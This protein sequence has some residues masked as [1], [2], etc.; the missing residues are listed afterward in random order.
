MRSIA[1]ALFEDVVSKASASVGDMRC[2]DLCRYCHIF[3]SEYGTRRRR[4]RDSCG[5]K[6]HPLHL[7]VDYV[8]SGACSTPA[9]SKPQF[10]RWVSEMDV[11]NPILVGTRHGAFNDRMQAIRT[12]DPLFGAKSISMVRWLFE[13]RS[14]I[15]DD[16]DLGRNIRRIV[17]DTCVIQRFWEALPPSCRRCCAR[18]GGGSPHTDFLGYSSTLLH[19]SSMDLEFDAVIEIAPAVPGLTVFC[20]YCSSVSAI[21]FEYDSALRNKLCVG[22]AQPTSG[23]HYARIAMLHGLHRKSATSSSSSS[24]DMA[25]L[26]R[27]SLLSSTRARRET[28]GA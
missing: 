19:G 27:P 23:G 20:V 5:L 15:F 4:Q 3:V 11:Q 8:M 7:I 6:K 18:L 26:C 10:L 1:G 12:L 21:S 17:S 13:G 22:R 25:A 14:H 2:V 28:N 24:A 9:P 16:M